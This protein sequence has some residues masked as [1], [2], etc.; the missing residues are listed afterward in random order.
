MAPTGSFSRTSAMISEMSKNK[1]AKNLILSLAAQALSLLVSFIVGFIV[2]KFIPELEYSF[3]QMF[4]L[5]YGYVGIFHFGL[6]DGIVLRY[7]QYDY[8]ELDKPRLRSQ[9]AVLLIL[10]G[11]VT[12]V[13]VNISAL[14][15]GGNA[16]LVALLVSAGIILKNCFT[17]TLYTFQMTNR[18]THY[19][20]LVIGQRLVYGLIMLGL[21]A[22]GVD[23]FYWYCIADLA[24]ELL[25]ALVGAMFNRGLYFGRLISMRE[26]LREAW[27]NIS[28]GAFLLVA[29][30]SSMLIVGSAKMICQWRFDELV[31]GKVAFSFSVANLFLTFVSAISVV[32]FPSLKRMREEEYPDTYGKIRSMISPVLFAVLLAYFPGCWI[33]TRWLPNYASSLIYLGILLPLIVFSSKTNLLTNNYL[34]VY[35][36]ERWMLWINLCAVIFGATLSFVCAYVLDDLELMLYALILTIMLYSFAS[37]FIVMRLIKRVRVID[38]AV[39]LGMTAI[40]IFAARFC[41]LWIGC[42]VYALAL[43]LYGILYHRSIAELCRPLWRRLKKNK[44][45]NE[46]N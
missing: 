44:T 21:L 14:A 32:L 9:F 10:T 7:A 8:E 29:N 25:A 17:Y 27:G 2:P 13:A 38:F 18:I 23:D 20:A 36:K 19:A 31:F 6:I 24:S 22:F 41:S 30:L 28:S 15:M 40:F 37:E 16:R 39:E 34:K 43:V 12:L 26:A 3:W 46:N 42:G 11:A 1:L 33:L 4:L 35:R 5:Y 45:P